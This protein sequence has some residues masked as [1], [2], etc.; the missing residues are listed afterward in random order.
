[1]GQ[2][3]DEAVAC[4]VLFT[5]L[6]SLDVRCEVRSSYPLQPDMSSHFFFSCAWNCK[7]FFPI[8]RLIL[9]TKRAATSRQ[10]SWALH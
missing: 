4:K 6:R 3:C 9:A 1:M 10:L 5:Y 7:V 2:C 8:F